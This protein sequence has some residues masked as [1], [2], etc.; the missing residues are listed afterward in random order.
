MPHLLLAQAD[1]D[2]VQGVIQLATAGGFS[3]LVWYLVI[4]HIPAIQSRHKAERD[5]WLHYIQRRD[6]SFDALV[7]E[8]LSAIHEVREELAR[9]GSK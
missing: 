6:D 9:L 4:K 5:E 3:A 2:W 7:R 1:I 8:N